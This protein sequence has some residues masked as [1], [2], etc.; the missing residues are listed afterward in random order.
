[1]HTSLCGKFPFGT[2]TSKDRL[3]VTSSL[4]PLMFLPLLH[5]S[6][7][8]K[9]INRSIS[10]HYTHAPCAQIHAHRHAHTYITYTH[11]YVHAG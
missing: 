5:I 9:H 11:A 7:M 2:M 8:C 3:M 10:T 1:M 6:H 4:I